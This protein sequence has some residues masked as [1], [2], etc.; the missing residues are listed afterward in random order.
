M[1]SP[2]FTQNSSNEPKHLIV[3]GGNGFLG[4]QIC[5]LASE[6]KIR[7]IS[8]S[9]S[10]KPKGINDKDYKNVTWVSSDIFNP[11]NWK[12]CLENC[13]A[14]IHSIGIIEEVPEKGITYEKMILKS[15]EVVGITAKEEGIERFIFISAGASTPDTP[16][17]YME[18]KIKTENFLTDLNLNLVILRPCMLYGDEDPESIAINEHIQQLLLDPNAPQKLR[19]T[20][21]LPV[22][23]VAKAAVFAALNGSIAGKINVDEIENMAN[24]KLFF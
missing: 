2:D 14:V 16:K 23:T 8:I 17:G 9:R 6:I 21:P 22:E 4:K 13:I 10:G 11:A 3:T 19:S 12:K 15:A 24:D 5:R 1:E 7:V 20:R 18:Y